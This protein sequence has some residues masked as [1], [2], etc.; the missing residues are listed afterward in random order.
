MTDAYPI[1]LFADDAAV[2]RLAAG[3]LSRT[4]PRAEWTHEGHLAACACLLL[5]YPHLDAE[6][7]LPDTIAANN[8]AVG[9]VN[10]ATQGFTRRSP[11]SMSR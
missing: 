7:D 3:L 8:V 6:R 4:L 11:S 9:G 2:R 1:R 5:D 10:N